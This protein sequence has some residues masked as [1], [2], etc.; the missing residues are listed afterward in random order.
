M[1]I[2]W[3]VLSDRVLH[4]IIALIAMLISLI[5]PD[6]ALINCHQRYEVQSATRYTPIHLKNPQIWFKKAI[7][8]FS[9]VFLLNRIQETQPNIHRFTTFLPILNPSPTVRHAW[10]VKVA[11]VNRWGF[12]ASTASSFSW[13][14][15]VD[16]IKRWN[17]Y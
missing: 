10:P 12:T 9:E 17:C 1:I 14:I 7:Y 5:A 15:Q 3:T 13:K 11:T 4:R 16:T 6:S 8:G 2:S